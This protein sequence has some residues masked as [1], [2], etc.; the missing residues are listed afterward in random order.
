MKNNYILYMPYLRN[1][2]AYDHDFWYTCVKWWYLQ[3]LFFIYF[4]YIFIFWT[5][6]GQK[7]AQDDKKILQL[8]S[9]EPY[10]IWLSFMVHLCKL[11]ISLGFFFFFFFFFSKFW[12]CGLF[13]RSK[14]KK[15]PKI[16]KNFVL[17]TLYLRNYASFLDL[18]WTCVK[19][20]YLHVFFTFFLNFNFWGQ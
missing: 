18:W 6:K 11:M 4:F 3:V 16:T 9:Q 15:L 17:C 7:M 1:S 5:V 19:A 20:Q 13:G 2:I 10:I 8:M 12:F 14:D